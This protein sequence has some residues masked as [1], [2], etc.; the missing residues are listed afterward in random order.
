VPWRK[1]ASQRGQYGSTTVAI[2]Q[3]ELS[4]L[5]NFL[6]GAAARRIVHG[7]TLLALPSRCA[8]S[9]FSFCIG[10]VSPRAV[11]RF[12]FQE[13]IP[14]YLRQE[15]FRAGTPRAAVNARTDAAWDGKQREEIVCPGRRS[16]G[17]RFA[18]GR[19]TITRPSLFMEALRLVNSLPRH[20]ERSLLRSCRQ[21]LNGIVVAFR[22]CQDATR[23]RPTG[24]APTGGR[25]GLQA[26]STDRPPG[27]RRS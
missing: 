24:C 25:P 7:R 8:S 20:H 1:P 5:G 17:A 4:P 18:A 12:P 10:R 26:G 2:R 21:S 27:P 3:Y 19:A 9:G 11:V 16:P 15:L 13:P 22:S 6:A 23:P 14:K